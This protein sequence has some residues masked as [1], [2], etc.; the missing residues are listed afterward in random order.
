MDL[1]ELLVAVNEQL[2]MI[3]KKEQGYHSTLVK[4]RE[5]NI[6]KFRLLEK[7]LVTPERYQSFVDRWLEYFSK[8][9]IQDRSLI[10][11]LFALVM[12]N[13]ESSSFKIFIDYIFESRLHDFNFS[14]KLF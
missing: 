5:E 10:S 7:W 9:E 14:I 11:G 12:Q 13:Y 2:Q 3:E 6:D 1:L 4:V 8:N